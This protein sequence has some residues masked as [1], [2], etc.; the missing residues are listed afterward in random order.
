MNLRV[1]NKSS[2]MK[3]NRRIRYLMFALLII[4][5]IIL[6]YPCTP[7]ELGDDSFYIHSLGGSIS[8]HGHAQWVLHPL[9]LLGLYPFSYPSGV[10]FIISEISQCTGLN[11]ELIILVVATIFGLLSLFTSY[12][13]AGA[14]WDDD[15]FKF[16]VAFGYSLSPLLL[17]FTIWTMS[18]R[19]LF[20]VLL[21]L[22]IWSLFK[23]HDSINISKLRYY[24]LSILLLIVLAVIH[25]MF[26][27]ALILYFSFFL[28][29][30]LYKAI[31]RI[32]V[33]E[34][35]KH[36]MTPISLMSFLFTL[37]I[38][39]LILGALEIPVLAFLSQKVLWHLLVSNKEIIFL[40]LL[41]SGITA[42]FSLIFEE[43]NSI[44]RF[45]SFN[46]MLLVPT[47]FL[48]Q[49]TSLAPWRDIQ[50]LMF[51]ALTP[52]MP[53][54]TTGAQGLILNLSAELGNRL[55]FFLL[56]GIIG[57]FYI[58][59]KGKLDYKKAF[60]VTIFIIFLPFYHIAS[61]FYES[62]AFVFCVFTGFLLVA[63][64]DRF[65]YLGHANLQPKKYII[66]AKKIIPVIIVVLVLSVSIAFSGYTLIHR[67]NNIGVFGQRNYMTD[68]EY[69]QGLF[70]KS[71]ALNI[72]VRG[73][74]HSSKFTS[75]RSIN[76][77]NVYI[78][79]NKPPSSITSFSGWFSYFRS[80]VRGGIKSTQKR[81]S[82]LVLTYTYL[83]YWLP[84]GTYKI[85]DKIYCNGGNNIWYLKY[86]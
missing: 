64:L 74:T 60:L 69:N 41:L 33:H 51:S 13:M 68:G 48:I 14:I 86:E 44:K 26:W 54:S 30:F 79:P 3:F 37:A 34:K 49:F 4:L 56:L 84:Q 55:G 1:N 15:R 19:G 6:R 59:W 25:R 52:L 2:K 40:A 17:K 85:C 22:F 58:I 20:I 71:H 76:K 36:V 77:S 65:V 18:T 67:Y 45:S 81:E 16:L 43:K 31:E 46:L 29:N 72:T 11:M 10:P 12:L 38:F 80:P 62:F 5:N 66:S 73:I 7:H 53:F 23:G 42:I 24:V 63:L 82:E 35:S 47:L 28:F 57:V 75:E 78:E 61:Y 21:P 83:P 70:A 27:M 39:S 9:S 32:I 8:L 50:R